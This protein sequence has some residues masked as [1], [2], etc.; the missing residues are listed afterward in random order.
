MQRWIFKKLRDDQVI[1][2]LIEHSKTIIKNHPD[3]QIYVGCDSQNQGAHTTYATA[4]VYRFPGKGA[5]VVTTKEKVRRI[6]DMWS[7]LWGEL[8]RS[9]DVAGYLRFEGN[10]PI[11]KIELDFNEG[12]THE[13]NKVFKAALGYVESL[14]YDVSY[15]D[16][17]KGD[18]RD[19]V[20]ISTWIADK[21]CRR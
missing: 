18:R 17:M 14:G 16:N 21:A 13:S 15:K 12:H 11:E 3:V 10:I 4:V 5:T 20:L 8:Q 1:D 19:N 6:E 7:K 9:I 2:N